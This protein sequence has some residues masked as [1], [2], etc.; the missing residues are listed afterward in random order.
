M[1][2]G[3]PVALLSEAILHANNMRDMDQDRK[4]G[5][6][7]LAMVSNDIGLLWVNEHQCM[8]DAAML[9]QATFGR[10]VWPRMLSIDWRFP[11]LMCSSMSMAWGMRSSERHKHIVVQAYE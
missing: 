6:F 10:F 5:I 9:A 8:C 3:L 4:A 2:Y 7:T 11:H 1:P